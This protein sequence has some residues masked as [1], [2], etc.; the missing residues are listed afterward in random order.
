M[1]EEGL[2]DGKLGSSSELGWMVVRLDFSIHLFLGGAGELD[3]GDLGSGLSGS[4]ELGL[5]CGFLTMGDP[6]CR[7]T[8]GLGLADLA[9]VWP[10]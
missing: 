2:D 5:Q 4:S 1:L 10:T 6:R 8:A 7:P 9:W 3:N